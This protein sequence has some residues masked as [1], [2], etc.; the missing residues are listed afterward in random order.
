MNQVYQDKRYYQVAEGI[1]RNK[2]FQRRRTFLHHQDSV[3]AHSLRVSYV[4]YR[5]ATFLEKYI[6][7]SVDDGLIT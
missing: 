4:A 3:Y 5:M 1:L 2:E 7:I 6:S